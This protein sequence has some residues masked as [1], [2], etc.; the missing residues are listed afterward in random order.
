MYFSIGSFKVIFASE[1]SLGASFGSG[2]VAV[3]RLGTTIRSRSL[4]AVNIH[5]EV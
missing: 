4:S 3:R 2:V 5:C 1:C